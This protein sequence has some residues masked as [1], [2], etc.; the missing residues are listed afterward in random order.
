[1][2]WKKIIHTSEVIHNLHL[3]R[4]K[5]NI[6]SNITKA[7][8]TCSL[9]EMYKKWLQKRSV[10]SFTVETVLRDPLQ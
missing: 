8:I 2:N 7:D 6:A 3:Y 10:H 9:K 1:M 4:K 5:Q